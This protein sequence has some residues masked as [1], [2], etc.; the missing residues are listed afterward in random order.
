[1]SMEISDQE[2]RALVRE[3]IAKEAG[4]NRLQPILPSPIASGTAPHVSHG[5]FVL[6]T[7]GD[8]DGRCLIE[9]AVACTHCGYCQSLGH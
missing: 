1:M 6:M 9:P 8:A 5:R 2:L 3:A 4:G 7:S